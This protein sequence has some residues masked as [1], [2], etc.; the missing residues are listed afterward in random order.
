VFVPVEEE[1]SDAE[2]EPDADEGQLLDWGSHPEV[3][4]F[5]TF[6]KRNKSFY[7]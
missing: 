2:A 6:G 5:Q 7:S 3:N 4:L 1:E